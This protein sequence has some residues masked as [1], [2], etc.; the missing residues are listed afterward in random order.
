MKFQELDML[1]AVYDVRTNMECANEQPGAEEWTTDETKRKE[2]T[3]RILQALGCTVQQ[4][5]IDVWIAFRK[6]SNVNGKK[7]LAL[8]VEVARLHGRKCFYA[9]RGLGECSDEIDLER[10]IP[11]T[12]GGQYTVENCVLSCSRHNRMRGD[13]SLEDMLRL[14]QRWKEL[15][16]ETPTVDD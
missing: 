13:K 7:K 3:R 9:N 4:I 11:E 5:L 1:C 6:S 15:T 10:L 16:H 12:R 8:L 14:G 2:L